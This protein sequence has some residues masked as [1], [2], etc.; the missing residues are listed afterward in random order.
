M[1]QDYACRRRTLLTKTNAGGKRT[2]PGVEETV[3]GGASV[4]A[5]GGVV[6]HGRRLQAMLR[7]FQTTEGV[8]TALPFLL[9]MA[10]SVFGGFL[11]LSSGLLAV[12]F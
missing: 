2:L 7:L 9:R 11:L 10:S 1:Q 12:F 3:A 8:V 6:A 5:D 4:E